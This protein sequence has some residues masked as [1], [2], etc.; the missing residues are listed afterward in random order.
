MKILKLLVPVLIFAGLAEPGYSNETNS[1]IYSAPCMKYDEF[2][3]EA[4]SVFHQCKQNANCKDV[5]RATF[6]FFKE[7]K[8]SIFGAAKKL[9][10]EDKELSTESKEYFLLICKIIF[11][12]ITKKNYQ[13]LCE[14]YR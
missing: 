12:H 4:E 3:K 1:I 14:E 9:S 10:K 8:M 6:N 5:L 13:S 7:D 2:K 11:D